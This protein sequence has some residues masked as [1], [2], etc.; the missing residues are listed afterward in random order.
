M[1]TKNILTTAIL[2]V[3]GVVLSTS[4]AKAQNVNHASQDL[5]M[6]LQ[7]SN[8]AST[9][10]IATLGLVGA[11]FRDAAPG[12]FSL[13]RTTTYTT[14]TGSIISS[15]GAA[16]SL[17]LLSTLQQ[18]GAGTTWANRSDLWLGAVVNIGSGTN[19]GLNNLT[20]L[21]PQG[22]LYFTQARTSVGT[23]GQAN[24]VAPT[25]GGGSIAGITS[26]TSAVVSNIEL[27]S[28]SIANFALGSTVVDEQNPFLSPTQQGTAYGFFGSGVQGNFDSA[29]SINGA[30]FGAAG[31]V[32]LALDL[33]RVQFRN[34]IA[35]QAGFG[36]AIETPLYLGSLTVAQN[37]DVG[38]LAATPVPEPSTSLLVGLTGIV[39]SQLRRRRRVS[40]KA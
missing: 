25:V 39:A 30:T 11:N 18:Y 23:V 27:A 19:T 4:A 16:G 34:N 12:S 22:T 6:T 28:G 32:E 31:A 9:A 3:A 21:D 7:T 13:L 38:F 36:A 37:G 17:N 35:T 15:N 1:K 29:A 5:I 14:G 10:S 40:A 26:A 33:Y 24:S 20:Q 2:A 8:P